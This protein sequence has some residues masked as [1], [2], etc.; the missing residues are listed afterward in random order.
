MKH[1]RITKRTAVVGTAVLGTIVAA[2]AAWAVFGSTIVAGA[3]GGAEIVQ[4]ITVVGQQL[5][6]PLLPGE[7]SNV[8]LAIH[9]PN[10]NV[11]AQVT[12]ISPGAVTVSGVAEADVDTCKAYVITNQGMYPA[13]P[14]LAKGGDF[15]YTIGDGVK[16]GDAPLICQG[17]TWTTNW[18]VT[19]QAVR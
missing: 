16:F 19:F 12:G 18:N 3:T 8:K 7:S 14:T 9:N 17:M 6:S 2:T 4:E 11:R 10:S 13:L 5:S 15:D 1:Q